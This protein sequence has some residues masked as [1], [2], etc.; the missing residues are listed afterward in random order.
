MFQKVP[1]VVLIVYIFVTFSDVKYCL[2]ITCMYYNI[3]TKDH[4]AHFR[5]LEKKVFFS[6]YAKLSLNNTK[7][8]LNNPKL[9]RNNAKY[10][11]HI[12]NSE[13]TKIKRM[14]LLRKPIIDS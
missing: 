10:L 11:I 7:H 9:S 13:I 4:L 8:T 6:L 5:R 12:I 14:Y 2:F 1:H 3:S